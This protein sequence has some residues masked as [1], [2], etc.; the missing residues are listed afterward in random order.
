M[1]Q[2]APAA[3]PLPRTQRTA[4]PAIAVMSPLIAHR[5]AFHFSD[6]QEIAV[7]L[8]PHLMMLVAALVAWRFV[9]ALPGD[10]ESKK[11][12]QLGLVL[13]AGMLFGALA[14]AANLLVMLAASD[15]AAQGSIGPRVAAVVVQVTLLSPLAEELAF[16]GL[17]YRGLRQAFRPL[18]AAL[19]SAAIFALMH[20]A[21]AQTLWAFVLGGLLAF[22]YEQTRSLVAPV[23]AHALFNAVPV[24]VAVI[25]SR[26]TDFS[27]IWL[28][29]ALLAVVFALAAR[30][31]TEAISTR[32]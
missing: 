29:I 6:G 18:V 10:G 1:N 31:A 8:L 23:V 15:E 12:H 30:S 25:R 2:N 22:L 14:A 11:P 26:P 4:A 7:R 24:G 16:R 27:A 13:A 5:L 20:G 28:A 32:R 19:L 3:A 21:L 9:P 17:L